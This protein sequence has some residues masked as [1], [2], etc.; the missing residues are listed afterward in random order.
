[1]NR[2]LI[3]QAKSNICQARPEPASLNTEAVGFVNDLFKSLQVAYPAW[4]QAFPTD[5]DLQLAKKS[6]IRAFA[7]NGVTAKEQ[8]AR[9]MKRARRDESDFFPSVGKF[10]SWCR[11]SP[12]EMGL[13]SEDLAW[14]EINQHSHHVLVHK[15]SHPA[16]YEAGSRTGWFDI[17]TRSDERERAGLRKAFRGHYLAVIKELEQGAEFTI[18]AADETRLEHHRNGEQVMTEQSK[19]K[20]REIIRQLRASLG[21]NQ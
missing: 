18:P 8:V 15:W 13:P 9:G 5:Q 16:I 6:W 21:M 4:R 1:M 17:R 3:N 14:R 7:E 12:E 2:Q 10:I 20:S 19:A 11:L